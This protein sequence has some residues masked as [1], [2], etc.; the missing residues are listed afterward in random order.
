M[1]SN[2]VG[3]SFN[4]RYQPILKREMYN[5]IG[6]FYTKAGAISK[7]ERPDRMFNHIRIA[8]KA[9][10]VSVQQEH[11]YAKTSAPDFQIQVSEFL[12]KIKLLNEKFK[13]CGI[14]EHIN[15]WKGIT[16]DKWISKTVRGAHIE[17]EDLEL[18]P[19]SGLSVE[20]LLRSL[21]KTLFRK[22]TKRLSE[23]YVLR[24]VKEVEQEYV[25]SIFLREKKNNQH[26]LILNLKEFI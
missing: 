17:I 24:P 22:K 3:Q 7:E 21:E 13:V 12:N 6:L 9:V 20:E 15:N 10:K 18:V 14:F 26:S 1:K 16:S 19:L 25:S 2:K 8:T 11:C 4:Q 5:K 23:K